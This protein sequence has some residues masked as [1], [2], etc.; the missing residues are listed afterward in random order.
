VLHKQNEKQLRTIS[1][2]EPVNISSTLVELSVIE[3]PYLHPL[4]EPA[5]TP[6]PSLGSV[7]K[8]EFFLLNLNYEMLKLSI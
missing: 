2:V 6:I 7:C 5:F 3:S 1:E 4:F 8:Y